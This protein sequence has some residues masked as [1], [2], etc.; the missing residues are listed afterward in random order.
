MKTFRRGRMCPA[1]LRD[2]DSAPI[3]EHDRGYCCGPCANGHLCTCLV[4][5]DG[6]DDGVDR[7]GMP[8][9][10]T[11]T[12]ISRPLGSAAVDFGIRDSRL[13]VRSRD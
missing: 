2:F 4:E 13:P 10:E 9:A 7:L 12:P 3:F 11:A 8:F 5:V 6:N 1:C